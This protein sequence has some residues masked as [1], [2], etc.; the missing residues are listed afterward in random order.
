MTG[1]LLDTNCFI[2]I[3]R[4]RPDAPQVRSLLQE[5]PVTQLFMTDFTVHSIGVVML[6]FNQINGYASFLAGLGIGGGFGVVGIPVNRLDLVSTACT[7]HRLDFDDAY[8]Y[9]AAE[10]H[11]LTLVSLDVDFDRTPRGR[12]TPAAALQAF[13]DEQAKQAKSQQGP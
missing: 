3:V 1:F 12:L 13:R 10:L 5:V 2:Q 9:A 8:Q 7:T 6:R 11:N 4:S